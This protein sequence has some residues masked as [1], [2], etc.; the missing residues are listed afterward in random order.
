MKENI[1][2]LMTKL[3]SEQDI[4]ELLIASDNNK[5]YNYNKDGLKIEIKHTDNSKSIV[6]TYDNPTESI[7]EQFTDNLENIEDNDFIAI[8]EF[9]GKDE[10]NR[11]QKLVDSDS[12]EDIEEGINI[13]KRN[14][15]DYVDDTINHLNSLRIH[16]SKF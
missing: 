3:M 14:V 7:K 12:V 9:I 15:Y 16:I 13:F 1:D 11:I 4:K 5:D 2:E 8:C 6:I 10:L